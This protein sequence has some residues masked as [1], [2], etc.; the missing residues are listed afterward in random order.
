MPLVDCL[1]EILRSDAWEK[2]RPS[3]GHRVIK[4]KDEQ[5]GMEICIRASEPV[6]VICA[7]KEGGALK[8][9]SCLKSGCNKICDYLVIFQ[10][11]ANY[12]AVFIEMKENMRGQR[13]H[14]QLRRSL[15]ILDY[16]VSACKIEHNINPRISVKYVLV[17]EKV[18]SKLD[19]QPIRP[20]ST[21]SIN[22]RYKGIMVKEFIGKTDFFVSAMA[23]LTNKGILHRHSS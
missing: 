17:S 23:G 4:L 18:N 15:P 19:K 10:S 3:N 21:K 12:Y 20:I 9:L 13:G 1:K 5:S 7:E 11:N 22:K 6:L 14:E 8:H 2:G 16:L